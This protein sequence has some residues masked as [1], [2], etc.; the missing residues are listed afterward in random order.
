M[1][2]KVDVLCHHVKT[3]SRNCCLVL[4]VQLAIFYFL[5][6]WMYDIAAVSVLAAL[7]NLGVQLVPR[8][9]AAAQVQGE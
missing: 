7:G 2:E 6:F 1:K 8:G 5:V 9:S 3:Q 4:Q